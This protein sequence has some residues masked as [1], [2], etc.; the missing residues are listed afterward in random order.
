[1]GYEKEK[2]APRLFIWRNLSGK[3]EERK[4]NDISL[5][6]I[7]RE[8]GFLWIGEKPMRSGGGVLVGKRQTS[9][10]GGLPENPSIFKETKKKK[11]FVGS[12]HEFLRKRKEKTSDRKF[13]R[14]ESFI[15]RGEV[16]T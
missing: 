9:A 5:G 2:K 6:K 11:V 13:W 1:V 14:K 8:E 7:L 3:N 16:L 12:R 10:R 4:R 15:K